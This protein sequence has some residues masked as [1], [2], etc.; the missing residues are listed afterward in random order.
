MGWSKIWPVPEAGG[1]RA[2][3]SRDALL[4]GYPAAPASSRRVAAPE[5]GSVHVAGLGIWLLCALG[6]GLDFITI[7]GGEGGTGAAPMTFADHV[8]LPFRVGF[9][10]VYKIFHDAGIAEQL[11]WI[12]SREPDEARAQRI[13]QRL[14]AE[15]KARLPVVK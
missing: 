14:S 9:T 12:G 11:V 3:W 13:V 2:G 15:P 7:D 8:S 6:L 5:L 4:A 1:P 10:R